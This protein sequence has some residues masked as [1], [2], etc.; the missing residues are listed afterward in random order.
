MPRPAVAVA[1]AG[2]RSTRP[3]S[4][5]D[6]ELNARL[7]TLGRQMGYGRGLRPGRMQLLALG[8]VIVAF[9]LVVVFGRALGQLNDA[10]QR[11]GIA[12]TEAATLQA[13]LEAGRRELALV[14]T[15]AFQRIQARA[16]GMG[17]SGEL[18]FTLTSDG[19]APMIVP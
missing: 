12:A 18:V 7:T 3:N 6:N 16:L 11:Q 15:D 9:W 4:G 8:I 19:P 10:T 14:Q 2:A 13:Q 5:P 1:S 17:Q